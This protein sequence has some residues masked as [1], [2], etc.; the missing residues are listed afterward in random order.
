MNNSIPLTPGFS[1]VMA[2]SECQNRF[3]GL[4]RVG[5]PLKRLA[6]RDAVNTR[7]KPGVSENHC[8]SAIST[9]RI[10]GNS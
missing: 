6:G 1:P 4:V 3:N 10:G 8:L 5:K 9:G 7:L 2:G